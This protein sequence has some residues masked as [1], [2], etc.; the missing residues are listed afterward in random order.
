MSLSAEDDLPFDELGV[1]D[2]S[3]TDE[4]PEP[5]DTEL[6]L[7]VEAQGEEKDLFRAYV[8]EVRQHKL[9]KRDEELALAIR[10]QRGDSQAR[11][12]LINCNL[13]LVISIAKHF[14]NRGL[15][16]LDLI[17]EGNIGL[18]IAIEKFDTERGFKLSTYATWWIK[19][20]ISRAIAE[21]GGTIRVPV[22]MQEAL[23]KLN[24]ARRFLENEGGQSPTLE[25]L[26]R[27]TDLP[28]EKVKKVLTADK[29]SRTLACE[30]PTK[31][32]AKKKGDVSDSNLEDF[33]KDS[34]VI[35]QDLVVEAEQALAHLK[36]QIATFKSVMRRNCTA[37]NAEIVF[38]RCGLDTISKEP[39]T[40]D[41]VGQNYSVTR[42]RVRQITKTAFVATGY[43]LRQV[44]RWNDRIA[45]LQGVLEEQVQDQKITYAPKLTIVPKLPV[46]NTTREEIGQF[47]LEVTKLPWIEREV[48]QSR[49]GLGNNKNGMCSPEKIATEFGLPIQN[50]HRILDRAWGKVANGSRNEKWLVAVLGTGR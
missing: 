32:S 7:D 21:K 11:E 30:N 48:F 5:D 9:L 3:F 18:M 33:L 8:N 46:A 41:E 35:R 4:M 34:R 2:S 50:V 36:S 37:R 31:A 22:H 16:F 20:S 45:I 17:Q 14:Q 1:D 27:L 26:S 38:E 6:E 19:Q 47:E 40:L 24:Q 23:S 12:K 42:E 25:Q 29:V 10:A 13:R 39:T 49:Y 44:V 15:D 28:P 43:T